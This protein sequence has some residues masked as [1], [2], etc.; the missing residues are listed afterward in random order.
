MK[1]NEPKHPEEGKEAC[2][3]VQK[4]APPPPPPPPPYSPPPPPP[5]P[6]QSASL[7]TEIAGLES[8]IKKLETVSPVLAEFQPKV[9]ELEAVSAALAELQ[10]KVNE[11]EVVSAALAELQSKVNKLEAVSPALVELRSKVSEL[12]ATSPALAELR[13][14]VNELEAVS[15]ALAE[16]ESEIKKLAAPSPALAELGAA[17]ENCSRETRDV[18][19]ALSPSLAKL[20]KD[21]NA[22]FS[23]LTA[24]EKTAERF[25]AAKPKKNS[26]DINRLERRLKSLEAG[27]SGGPDKN[28]SAADYVPG[29]ETPGAARGG[30]NGE[31]RLS[32]L[33]YLERR[34][35]RIE[36]K[37][38]RVDECDAVVKVLKAAVEAMGK[39]VDYVLRESSAVAGEQQKNYSELETLTREV[40]QMGALFNH[41][42]AELSSLLPKNK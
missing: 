9:N 42:R 22:V 41:F 39:N 38:E 36:E 16:L 6:Q 30:E 18:K 14:K 11:L 4:P 27:I 17:V 28:I 20:R 33:P 34:M 1:G 25:D 29:E 32:R 40:K 31:E 23:R 7:E 8:E 3:A 10:S 21:L 13:L 24:L 15:P 19:D 26:V 35:A 12:E 2:H 37:L 5:V